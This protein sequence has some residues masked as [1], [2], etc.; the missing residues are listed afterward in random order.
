[1][2]LVILM[3]HTFIINRQVVGWKSAMPYDYPPH[4][5]NSSWLSNRGQTLAHIKNHLKKQASNSLQMRF[6]LK[7]ISYSHLTKHTYTKLIH[8]QEQQEMH[9]L[10]KHKLRTSP[11]IVME[12]LLDFYSCEKEKS[13]N[14]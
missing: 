5:A 11:S 3:Y 4:M 13:K 1:M 10:W 7:A 12:I 8:S 6:S 2:G 14:K 9:L